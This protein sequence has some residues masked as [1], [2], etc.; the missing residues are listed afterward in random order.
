MKSHLVLIKRIRCFILF[1][2]YTS[3]LFTSKATEVD[4]S[5]ISSLTVM[6]Y[7]N[8]VYTI[9]G[10]TALRIYNPK[11]NTDFVFNWGTFDSNAPHFLYRFF[12]GETNYFLSITDYYHFI[13]HYNLLKATV[14]E[15]TLYLPPK[16]KKH[17]LQ[18]LSINLQPENR[19]YRYN[20]LKDNCTTRVRN[21]IEKATNCYL[22]TPDSSYSCTV[23]QLIHSCTYPYFWMTFGIDLLIGSEADKPICKREALFLPMQL[24]ETL[25]NFIYSSGDSLVVSSCKI[26]Q[27]NCEKNIHSSF[28]SSPTRIGWLILYIYGII[29]TATT[30]GICKYQKSKIVFNIL[31]ATKVYSAFLFFL[32]TIV[33]CLIMFL[34]LF[35][36]HPCKFPNWNLFW[37][38]P[39]HF[40]A[41]FGYFFRNPFHWITVYHQCNLI[42]LFLLLVG[43]P[44]VPQNLN[45]AIVPYIFCLILASSFHLICKKLLKR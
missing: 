18:M 23:R 7:S 36:Y 31:M 35:S 41:F 43:K 4:S 15:Q 45:P 21:L 32:A 39:L 6:P 22:D 37:L 19:I 24:K 17:L 12:K 3:I 27:Y 20:F 38:H 9:Y 42:L 26:L 10:H 1:F 29:I 11:H 40:I 33:G 5:Q 8:N 14:I 44:W 34:V 13:Q 2:L 25:D 16:G 28:L 30:I